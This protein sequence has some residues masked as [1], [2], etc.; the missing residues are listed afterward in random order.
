KSACPGDGVHQQEIVHIMARGYADEG[1]GRRQH[2]RE[3]RNRLVELCLRPGAS[4]TAIALEH[5]VNV[6][7]VFMWRRD[8]LKSDGAGEVT[9]PT[10]LPVR[11]AAGIEPGAQAAPASKARPGG[12]T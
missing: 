12:A 6:N 10:L 4:V 11:I 3:F 7:L 1:P 2:E 9:P 8:Q 5:G